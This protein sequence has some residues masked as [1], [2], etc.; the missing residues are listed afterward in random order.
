VPGPLDNGRRKEG[1][2]AWRARAAAVLA[3]LALGALAVGSGLDRE[4]RLQP[5]LAR[6]VPWPFAAEAALVR[7]RRLLAAG[8]Y[9]AVADEA[10]AAIRAAPVD[11]E[12][13]ALLGAARAGL[14]EAVRAEQAFLVAGR[15]GW[16]APLTQFYWFERAA[17]VG[18]SRV[19]ALRLDAILRASPALMEN[20][21][22]LAPLEA[23]EAGRAALADRLAAGPDW[24]KPYAD[25]LG[26]TNPAQV[27]IRADV[28]NR[29][30]ASGHALGCAGA[31]S[32]TGQLVSLGNVALAHE[33]WRRHCPAHTGTL[34]NDA[35]FAGLQV[36]QP[37]SPFDW[38]VIGDSDVSL[39]VDSQPDGTRRL[40]LASSAAFP[41]KMLTQLVRLA[42]GGYRL[43][44]RAT[45]AAGADRDRVVATVSCHPDSHD[46][47][48]TTLDPASHRFSADVAVDGSCPGQWLGFALLP[49]TDP[50]SFGAIDLQPRR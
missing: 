41:R 26:A 21:G 40:L 25:G 39:S 44:W 38:T 19:A 33:L 1:H 43:S 10:A 37:D 47:L 12:S 35:G 49:G 42:P 6:S 7:G 15:L 29:L 20:S 50:I 3:G 28:L 2:G 24:L 18:D 4:A 46:W 5:A 32:L 14:G 22:L 17:E 11:P 31:G 36:H 8:Q 23:S 34:L 16:R 9:R 27:A 48:A 13:T 30:A 45:D